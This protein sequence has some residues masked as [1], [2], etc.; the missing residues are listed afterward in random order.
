V[1]IEAAVTIAGMRWFNAM[2]ALS[3]RNE[4]QS[5]SRPLM[6][7]EMVLFGRRAGAILEEYEARKSRRR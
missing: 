2:H 4:S 1:E 5:S 6:L 3:T 7:P